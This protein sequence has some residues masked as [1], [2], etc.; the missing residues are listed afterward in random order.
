[1][2]TRRHF[3]SQS[4]AA[5]SALAFPLVS[6][7]QPRPIKVGVLHP[8]T[9]A[10]AY[11]GQ[12][13]RLGAMLAIE[14]INN[15]GG[16]KS[17][18]GAKLEAMLGDAQSNPQAGT[19]EIEKMNEAGVSAVVGAFASA[20]CLATT[21][22]AA[23]YNLP[24]VVDVGV[25]DQIVERGLKNTFRFGPG[26]KM[27]AQTAVASLHAL[28]T[29]AGKPAR[30][31]M[32][33]H[34]ESLFGTGTANLLASE[35]PGYGYEVKEVI[36]HANPTRDFNNIALRIRQVNPDI[37]IPA[38]YYN[39]YALLV[40]TLQQQK[41]TPKAIY[42]VLGGAASSY[43]FVKEFPD[44]A[45]G[46]IDCNHWFNPKDKRSADLRKRVEAKG[47]FFSY[48]VFMTYTAMKLLAD[49]I[50]RA[51]SADRAAIIDALTASKF[52]DHIMPYGATQF[53]NGQNTG[54]RPLMTQVQ[55]GDIKVIVP[56]EFREVEPIFPLKA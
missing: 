44:A 23:K 43:K 10:L 12:Q 34:E 20:I 46:I 21:Q 56:R 45:N 31:V 37:L 11:S 53:V 27:C 17:L 5:A 24:H 48:E 26:Y 15:A 30:T 9:G 2:S 47:Q 4:A 19:A 29:A 14:D 50:E 28:N 36:K 13:C 16:I 3:M 52:A 42:S 54:A 32:I 18:G 51:K 6:G 33:V 39:E 1:M 25:A 55:K 49:A 41:I 22:A 40:R 35:L 38:N 8:V 7:A